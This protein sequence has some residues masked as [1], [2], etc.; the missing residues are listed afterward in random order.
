[1]CCDENHIIIMNLL[2]MQHRLKLWSNQKILE[3]IFYLY[4]VVILCVRLFSLQFLALGLLFQH[5]LKVYFLVWPIY[6]C[7]LGW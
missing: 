6:V 2:H 3:Q 1:M 4:L 7:V 5:D